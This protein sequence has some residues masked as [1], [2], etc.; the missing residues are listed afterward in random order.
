MNPTLLTNKRA[1]NCVSPIGAVPNILFMEGI[2]TAPP[3]TTN[4][5]RVAPIKTL[6][7]NKPTSTEGKMV[8]LE[9][10]V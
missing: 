10:N 4:E 9:A 1:E 3:A 7:L 5:M 2:Y 6:F 8:D